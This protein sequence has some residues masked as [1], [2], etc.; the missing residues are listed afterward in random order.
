MSAS[1]AR[2][3]Q[4]ELEEMQKD[5]PV[6]C[7]AGPE[8]PDNL[9]KW[10]A[11]IVGPPDTPYEGGVF[12]LEINFPAD[13]PFRPPHFRFTTRIYHPNINGE[14]GICVDIL[15]PTSWSPALTVAKVLLSIS[16]LMADANPD[17]PLVPEI[18]HVYKTNPVLFQTT[19]R[20]WTRR[21]A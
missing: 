8:N 11:I 21:H 9:N 4:R 16:S 12:N 10:K 7:T 6:G 14:G 20:E 13:Y 19:A 2:R 18:A 5:P 15:K 17:D 1:W 3:I